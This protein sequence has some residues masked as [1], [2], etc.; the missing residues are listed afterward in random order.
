MKN[1]IIV[2]SAIIALTGCASSKTNYISTKN[3]NLVTKNI[4]GT[5]TGKAKQFNNNVTWSVKVNIENNNY[6]VSYPSLNCGGILTLLDSSK[7]QVKFRENITYGRSK[8]VD[9]GILTLST[10]SNNNAE[11]KWYYENGKFGALGLMTKK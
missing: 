7:T 1:I 9:N 11:Y 10:T 4:Q 3:V 6:T 8:C 2:V 5:W